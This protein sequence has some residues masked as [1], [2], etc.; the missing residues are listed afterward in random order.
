MK[1]RIVKRPSP[2]GA[3]ARYRVSY[4]GKK[5]R[6]MLLDETLDR[7][8]AAPVLF[9]AVDAAFSACQVIEPSVTEISLTIQAT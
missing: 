7:V 3:Q 2:E 5:A 6:G 1:L 8:G 9:H 4:R